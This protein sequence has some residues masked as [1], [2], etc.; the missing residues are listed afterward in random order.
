M[1]TSWPVLLRTIVICAFAGWLIGAGAGEVV[2]LAG[3]PH[4]WAVLSYPFCFWAGWAIS[5]WAHPA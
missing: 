4:W 1:G 2:D 3:L 5:D